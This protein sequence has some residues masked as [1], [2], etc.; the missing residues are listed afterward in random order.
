[1]NSTKQNLDKAFIR[2]Y[3]RVV[4]ANKEPELLSTGMNYEEEEKLMEDFH[5]A[6]LNL[7]NSEMIQLAHDIFE[8]TYDEFKDSPEKGAF[9]LYILDVILGDRPSMKHFQKIGIQLPKDKRKVMEYSS[10]EEEELRRI[11]M[12]IKDDIREFDYFRIDKLI[13]IITGES[14]KLMKAI[15]AKYENT[16]SG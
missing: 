11:I 12:L 10:K 6:I 16:P 8:I 9:A 13:H 3:I 1:M 2:A 7:S 5:D 14:P 15:W 4:I